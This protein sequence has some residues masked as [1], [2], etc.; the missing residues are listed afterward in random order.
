MCIFEWENPDSQIP[1]GSKVM[2][3]FSGLCPI[4]EALPCS[5]MR[6]GFEHKLFHWKGQISSF[7]KHINTW[8]SKTL[9][10]KNKIDFFHEHLS[11][12]MC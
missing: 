8:G 12:T 10:K 6:R 3:T 2:A 4:F 9:S 1:I 11:K 7:Q 5:T